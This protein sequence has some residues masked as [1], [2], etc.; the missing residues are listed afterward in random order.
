MCFT[1]K[2]EQI[3]CHVVKTMGD[4]KKG[5]YYKPCVHHLDVMFWTL[6][7]SLMTNH[8][9]FK[10]G[11][12]KYLFIKWSETSHIKKISNWPQINL[13]SMIYIKKYMIDNHTVFLFLIDPRISFNL[14]S[15]FRYL[16]NF[17]FSVQLM[18]YTVIM[19]VSYFRFLPLISWSFL[20]LKNTQPLLTMTTI[21][22]S[23]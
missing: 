4:V 12:H 2:Y 19:P 22:L 23:F 9:D 7:C 5:Y 16:S 1:N 3:R 18:I 11:Q 17:S 20:N 6:L 8:V 10:V 13:I 21:H 15:E 14:Q